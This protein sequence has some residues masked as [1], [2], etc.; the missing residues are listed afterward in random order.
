MGDIDLE[1]YII[2][3]EK[4]GVDASEIKNKLEDIISSSVSKQPPVIQ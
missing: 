3:L 1:E 2:N 4:L